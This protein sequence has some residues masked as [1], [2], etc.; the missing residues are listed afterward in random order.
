MQMR[1]FLPFF[2]DG[3][4]HFYK[5]FN[6]NE[7]RSYRQYI[8]FNLSMN[9]NPSFYLSCMDLIIFSMDRDFKHLESLRF[10]NPLIKIIEVHG[11]EEVANKLNLSPNALT[12]LSRLPPKKIPLNIFDAI[13]ELF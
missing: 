2:K 7:K 5:E 1:D 6:E 3:S 10:E 12:N 9:F 11:L 8:R 13:K 4:E